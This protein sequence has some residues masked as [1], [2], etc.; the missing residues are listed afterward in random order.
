MENYGLITILDG[1]TIWA[2]HHFEWEKHGLI[3]VF[4]WENYGKS[5]FW[6]G[7]LYGLIAIL[8][9]KSMG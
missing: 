9:G 1:K 4:L 3:T 7:K 6:I 8:N 2:N 5:Q